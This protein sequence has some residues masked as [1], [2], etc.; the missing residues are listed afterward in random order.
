MKAKLYFIL[1]CLIC[2]FSIAVGQPHLIDSVLWKIERIRNQAVDTTHVRQLRELGHDLIE[3]DSVLSK[4]LLE[5]A[6]TKSFITK[7]QNAITNCYRLLGIWYSYFDDKDHA[8]QHYRLSLHSA[9][10][11]QNLYLIA[12]AS[13]NI[14]N[15]NYWKGEYDSCIYYYLKAADVFESTKLRKER[16]ISVRLLDKRRSDLYANL[17]VVF[18]SI[19]NLAKADEYIDKAIAIAKQYNTPA[20]ADALAFYMQRKADNH[21]E[22]GEI[23][24]ALRIRM[25]HLP[26]LEQGRVAKTYVQGTY[27]AIAQEFF[28]LRV[29]DSA[30]LFAQKS[31][32]LAK[33]LKTRDGI[34]NASLLLAKLALGEHK[35]HLAE[36]HAAAAQGYFLRSEDP[37]E[38]RGYYRFMQELKSEMG[39]YKDAHF[40]ANQYIA[41]NDTILKGERAKQF[42]EL[43]AR[44]QSVK[45]ETQIKLQQAQLQQRATLTYILIGAVA[46]LL[47]IAVLVNRNHRQKQRLQRQRISELETEKQLTAAE[48]V[49]K[50]EEQERARLAKDLHDGL[51]GMLSGIKYSFQNM[52]GNLIMTPESQQTFERSMDMLDTS[53]KEMRRVAHNMMPEALVKFGLDTALRDFCAEIDQSGTLNVNYQS[54]S[55]ESATIAQTTA[56]T[57][58]RIVQELL[59]NTLKHAAAQQ[60]LVQVTHTDGVITVTVEDDGKGFNTTSV[61]QKAQGM[62]WSNILSRV[63]YL[64]GQVDVQ[65]HPDK[66]TSVW[67]ELAAQP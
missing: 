61:K 9:M 39:Q 59:N 55:L 64:K 40:Y 51:G 11:N 62:G 28:E 13:L 12:G 5:E 14:G 15:M 22:H 33:D 32:Q 31:L 2:R 20:A 47:T 17:S 19:K 27:Q 21:Y 30:Q 37:L 57:V 46:V 49:L 43:E 29:K 48:A 67:V 54:M 24:K 18:N 60:A 45:K 4:Q 3:V 66:G 38:Q 63:E 6:L 50:G 23:E 1:L 56:I 34:A 35:H 53:I 44:Y 10:Q 8:L 7:D 36:Q 65:S 26:Q 58:Y 52:K 42:S 25:I 16:I 41:L